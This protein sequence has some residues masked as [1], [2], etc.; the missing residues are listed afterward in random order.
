L[1]FSN[2]YPHFAHFENRVSYSLYLIYFS[3]AIRCIYFISK[4]SWA[5]HIALSGSRR[6]DGFDIQSPD[7][8]LFVWGF[9]L[10]F[11]SLVLEACKQAD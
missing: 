3:G 9:S 11:F 2:D 1:Y 7:C 4:C 6:R 8:T 5:Y 10:D